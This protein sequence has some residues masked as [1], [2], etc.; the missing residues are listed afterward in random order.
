MTS[1]Q[2]YVGTFWA[3]ASSRESASTWGSPRNLKISPA[4]CSPMATS[5]AA[6]FCTPFSPVLVT[7]AA[8][9]GRVASSVLIA[10]VLRHPSLDLGGDALGL[11]LHQLVE[12]MEVRV[13]HA[14]RQHRR[15]GVRE[16][17]AAGAG[18]ER[19]QRDRLLD[20]RDPRRRAEVLGLA[21][22]H[23]AGHEEQE[24][25]AREAQADPLERAEHRRRDRTRLGRD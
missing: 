20:L 14:R 6:A 15:R 11:A 9:S 10:L 22:A 3:L 18:L 19:G 16:V 13:R 7:A 17:I 23:A 21:L 2:M 1:R 25:E 12:L 5:R 24:D 4:R 8:P